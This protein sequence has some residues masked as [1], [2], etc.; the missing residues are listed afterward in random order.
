MPKPESLT[1]CACCGR[2]KPAYDYAPGSLICSLCEMLSAREAVMLTRE[3]FRREHS[4]ATFT[5]AGRKQA[6]IAAKMLHYSIHGKRCTACHD[7]KSPDAF[8]KCAPTPDGLQ[9]ICRD[10]HVLWVASVKSG[11]KA[12][13][14][15]I[16]DA[17]RAASAAR[18]AA[19]AATQ[20]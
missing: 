12:A 5:A 18:Q 10:C 13:W 11:G 7:Y 6:R 8:N 19:K 1:Y 4:V 9:A 16:R 2:D 3:T 20:K 15:T 14:H 17:L